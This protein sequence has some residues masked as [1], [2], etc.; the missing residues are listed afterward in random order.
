MLLVITFWCGSVEK[1]G[2]RNLL[3]DVCFCFLGGVGTGKDLNDVAVY[4]IA[5]SAVKVGGEAPVSASL[6]IAA[7]NESQPAQVELR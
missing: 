2:V 1:S 5:G 3:A 7:V 6:I 4:A